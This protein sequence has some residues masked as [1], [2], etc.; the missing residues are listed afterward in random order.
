[1]KVTLE[2]TTRVVTLNGLPA[3]IWEGRTE[4]GIQVHA[5][6]T[7]IAVDKDA[8]LRE[9]EAELETCRPPSEAV[10]AYPLRL[11]LP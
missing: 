7:R 2:S 3:R 6:I 10:E 4:S 1:M 11:F 5:F 8:D 9:F